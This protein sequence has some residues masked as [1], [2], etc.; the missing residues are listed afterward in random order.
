V[1][2][3]DGYPVQKVGETIDYLLSAVDPNRLEAPWQSL[4]T[5]ETSYTPTDEA[6]REYWERIL[7]LKET[8]LHD[9][10]AMRELTD[11]LW[12]FYQHLVQPY[13]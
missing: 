2:T 8:A 9:P 12:K 7:R 11:T 5:L 3:K 4:A 10:N 6:S 1:N 13:G